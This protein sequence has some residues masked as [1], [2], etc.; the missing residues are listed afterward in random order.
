MMQHLTR[1]SA[2]LA[3][4]LISLTAASA[5]TC[6]VADYYNGTLTLKNNCAPVGNG[7]YRCQTPTLEGDTGK[8]NA[9]NCHSQWFLQK[10]VR[11]TGGLVRS[12]DGRDSFDLEPYLDQYNPQYELHCDYSASGP[13]GGSGAYVQG[14]CAAMVTTTQQQGRRRR[15]H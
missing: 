11:Y 3:L 7:T 12:Y 14:W 5:Q 8:L 1:S 4:V 10:G 6:S 15:T 13:Q 9:V 2:A